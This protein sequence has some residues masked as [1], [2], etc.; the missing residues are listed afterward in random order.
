MHSTRTNCNLSPRSDGISQAHTK[1][2]EILKRAEGLLAEA[3]LEDLLGFLSPEKLAEGAPF[4]AA[5]VRYHFG[6]NGRKFSSKMLAGALRDRMLDGNREAAKFAAEGYSYASTGVSDIADADKVTEGILDNVERY[7]A[8]ILEKHPS[9]GARER[10]YLLTI[11][12]SE[13]DAENAEAL[14][15][16]DK[17]ILAEFEEIYE[18][19][20]EKTNRKLVDCI[21]AKDLAAMISSFLFGA[22]LMGRFN[23]DFKMELVAHTVVRIF[24]SFTYDPSRQKESLYETDIAE[25]VNSRRR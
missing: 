13:R 10:M 7:S 20:L 5:T 21:T 3:P 4:S 2:Q 15:S 6:V 18:L 14:R 11:L 8:Q 16:T 22:T 9:L 23:P 12:T 1:K 17:E 25:E 24:W 19:F